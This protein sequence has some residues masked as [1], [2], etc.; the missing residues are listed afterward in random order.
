MAR[1][2]I[3]DLGSNTARLVVFEYEPGRWFFL[4]NEIRE[5]VRLGQGLAKDGEVSRE[6][7]QR[8]VAALELF[9]DYAAS[10]GLEELEIIG[11]SAV[12]DA[13]NRGE[14]LAAIRELGF[15]VDSLS[16]EE[17][18]RL[19]VLAVANGFEAKDAWVMD[20]GGGSA[21][22]SRMSQRTYRQGR[23]FPL[24]A[25]RLTEA[26]LNTDPPKA[27]EV[28][29]LEKHVRQQ[30]AVPL[31]Q[32]AGDPVPLVAMGGT[33]RNLA[34]AA[35]KLHGY[36]VDVMHGY[37]L[38]STDLERITDMLLERPARKRAALP[39]ISG[40]RADIILAGALVYRQVLRAG[41]REGLWISGNGVRE[42]AF[43][44]RFLPSPHIVPNVRRFSVENLAHQY[45]Q[46]SAHLAHVRRLA[47]RL[48]EELES[49]H[50]LGRQEAELLDAAA[51]LHDVGM[52]VG[53][54]LHHKHG[55]YLVLAARLNGFD[56]REQALV[57]RLVRYHRKG[58]PK[59][60]VL[61]ELTREGDQKLL[62]TLTLCLRLAEMMERSRA[63][64]VR[65]LRATIGSE[66]V[67]LDVLATEEPVVELWE[68]NKQIPLFQRALDRRLELQWV[69]T[70]G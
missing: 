30:L 18:A 22:I 27:K 6:A 29:A 63:G 20:L 40:D 54:H 16:G 13:S 62:E 68:A 26:F 9:S 49:I 69:E 51:T 2:G 17:E 61:A 67:R 60:G 41:D 44:S 24:G 37:F 33:I 28:R 50:G 4:A 35:Q 45:Q 66:V 3:V 70:E 36:P 12:R 25:V 32:L 48:F 57:S 5:R 59:L 10:T 8:A 14:L 47:R 43:F 64:R 21:Q 46:P 58:R 23:S 56:H 42:G 7:M 53:Y 19:G 38:Q 39:G 11:T 52:T 34:R 15:D 65:D 1:V 31:D 55:A